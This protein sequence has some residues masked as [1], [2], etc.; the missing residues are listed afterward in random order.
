MGSPADMVE[1]INLLV[2]HQMTSGVPDAHTVVDTETWRGCGSE[3]VLAIWRPFTKTG[4]ACFDHADFG[5]VLFEIVDVHLAC[6]VAKASQ[7]QV[8]AVRR[9]EHGVSWAQRKSVY[10]LSFCIE[11]DR[12]RR[13]V[14]VDNG[15]AVRFG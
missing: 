15:K 4:V 8:S 12:L 9:E 13:H 10:C 2:V 1:L 11:D 3:N 5:I 6:K 14:S 7:K